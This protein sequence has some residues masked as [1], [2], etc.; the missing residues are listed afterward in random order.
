MYIIY[1][2][3]YMQRHFY[4][5]VYIC[6]ETFLFICIYIYIHIYSERLVFMPTRRVTI[7]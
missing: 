6:A 4:S 2:Y 3:I 1:I 7:E 5:C